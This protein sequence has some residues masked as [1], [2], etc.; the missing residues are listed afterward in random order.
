M[1]RAATESMPCG[2]LAPAL[3]TADPRADLLQSGPSPALRTCRASATLCCSATA[4][5]TASKRPAKAVPADCT[6]GTEA[7]VILT[8]PG[9]P[10]WSAGS[11]LLG[12]RQATGGKVASSRRSKRRQ[13]GLPAAL[14]C[15]PAAACAGRLP[16]AASPPARAWRRRSQQHWT[17]QQNTAHAAAHE[18]VGAAE[19]VH[20][21]HWSAEAAQDRATRREALPGREEQ[22]EPS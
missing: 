4:S 19:S 1:L 15:R 21:M 20:N 12:Q 14:H 8:M 3:P 6:K 17:W 2:L 11:R 22:G 16:A 9:S 10:G 5:C 7:A 13:S 18:E